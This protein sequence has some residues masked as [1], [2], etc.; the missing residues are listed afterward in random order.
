MGITKGQWGPKTSSHCNGQ[1]DYSMAG[2]PALIL[3]RQT[4]KLHECPFSFHQTNNLGI[5]LFHPGE[6]LLFKE[7]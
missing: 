7:A 5:V 1:R 6:K 4:L 2:P 3:R